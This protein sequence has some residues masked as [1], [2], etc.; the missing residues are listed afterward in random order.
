MGEKETDDE[1]VHDVL[2]YEYKDDN[3]KRLNVIHA[4]HGKMVLSDIS[5]H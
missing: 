1:T 4:K 2:I 3:S 5:G